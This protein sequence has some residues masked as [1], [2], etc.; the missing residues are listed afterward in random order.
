MVPQ[1]FRRKSSTVTAISWNGTNLRE[2]QEFMFPDSPLSPVPPGGP[3]GVRGPGTGG[4]LHWCGVG[5]WIVKD[6]EGCRIVTGAVFVAE[7]E[8]AGPQEI[9]G[10]KLYEDTPS[11]SEVPC[12]AKGVTIGG[13]SVP[14]RPCTE[15]TK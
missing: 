7:F 10:P 6:V 14:I 9:V 2:V 5:D 3:L 12:I 15:E 4:S 8:L 1:T 11:T 13:P